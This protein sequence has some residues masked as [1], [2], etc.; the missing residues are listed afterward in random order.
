MA[1]DLILNQTELE[2]SVEKLELEIE[3]KGL[4]N[5]VYIEKLQKNGYSV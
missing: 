1:T 2:Q 5:M 3:D 4:L